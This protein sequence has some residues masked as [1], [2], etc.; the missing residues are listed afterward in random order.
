MADGDHNYRGPP[1]AAGPSCLFLI[2]L[3][4]AEQLEPRRFTSFQLDHD[5]GLTT[6]KSGLSNHADGPGPSMAVSWSWR[7]LLIVPREI[8]P[9]RRWLLA[10]KELDI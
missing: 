2:S 5:S 7:I 1:A 3:L 9:F 8:L 6:P 10:G 4:S